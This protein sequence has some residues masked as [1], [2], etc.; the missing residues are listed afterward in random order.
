M[1]SEPYIELV[2]TNEKENEYKL[3][4]IHAVENNRGNELFGLSEG[5]Y[6]PVSGHKLFVLPGSL[7]VANQ[8]KKITEKLGIIKVQD[9]TKADIIIRGKKIINLKSCRVVRTD[10]RTTWNKDNLYRLLEGASN[11]QDITNIELYHTIRSGK[12]FNL[13]LS[14]TYNNARDVSTYNTTPSFFGK[15]DCLISN[16]TNLIYKQLFTKPKPFDIDSPCYSDED[17]LKFQI[18]KQG[19]ILDEETCLNLARMIESDDRENHPLIL[20]IL[21]NCDYNE[22]ALYILILLKEY[23]KRFARISGTN[24]KSFK[25][26]LGFF[27]LEVSII[28]LNQFNTDTVISALKH[29]GKYDKKHLEELVKI[30][31]HLF[32]SRVG[33]DPNTNTNSYINDSDEIE[34]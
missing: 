34:L 14:L 33:I 21:T 12:L 10:L 8:F 2:F 13:I 4:I 25:A 30:Q 23:E 11:F 5:Y 17:L 1:K 19:M 22:S 32:S 18:N 20:D 3:Q 28:N 26:M 16:S 9:I 6:Q 29:V 27:N 15:F 31:K 7:I 24:K